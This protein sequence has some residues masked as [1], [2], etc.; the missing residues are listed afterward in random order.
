MFGFNSLKK[1]NKF[2]GSPGKR[3]YAVGDVH[4]C[5]D[6]MYD[7][8]SLI[9]KDN[10]ALD[11]KDCIIV[12]LGDLIDRGPDSRAVLEYLITSPPEFAKTYCLKGNH[13]EM[14]LSVMRNEAERIP[15]W[16]TYGGKS[17]VESYGV[18]IDM[19][20][21]LDAYDMQHILR[22]YIPSSH[23][24][25]VDGMLDCISF[26]DYFLV[27]AGVDPEVSRE[28]QE[29]KTMRWIREPFL[30]SKTKL[31]YR[32]VHGH[33][34]ESEPVFTQNRIGIDTG[35]YETGILSAIVIENE[36]IRVISTT[37]NTE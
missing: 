37:G 7:L 20:S 10:A 27:H 36:D 33:T 14:L 28:D 12:F 22:K 17:F 5:Y 30:S 8:I 25:F 15:Q 26:E 4:G 18:D 35:C 9:E 13:E 29:P 24:D 19:L 11:P 1:A 16:L 6:E 34:I 2:S 3:L 32:V 23:L 21:S 31:G